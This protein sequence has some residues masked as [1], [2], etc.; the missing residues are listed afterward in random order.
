[1]NLDGHSVLV[2]GA[3][4]FVGGWLVPELVARGC[5]VAATHH[6]EQSAGSADVAWF[7]CELSDAASVRQLIERTH[8]DVVVHLAALA[9]PREA[10][11][12]PLRALQSN[13]VAVHHLLEAL[14]SHTQAAR[15]L[16]V[17][18]GEVYGRRARSAARSQESDPLLPE[19]VYAA[20][21]AAAE[22]RIE[23]AHR[24]WGL[25]VV[26]ARPFN[27]T[28]PGRPDRY[29]E[30]SFAR[31]IAAAEQ[32]SAKPVLRVGNLAAERDF[33]DVRDVVRAYVTLLERGV[34]GEIYNVCSGQ[35][36]SI[37]SI[38]DALISHARLPIEVQ[39]DAERF[40]PT[41]TGREALVGCPDALTRLGWHPTW[42]FDETLANLLEHWRHFARPTSVTTS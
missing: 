39:V 4:G 23:L 13:Y 12:A 11:R 37:R 34:T 25:D 19:N 16:F 20:T 35:P 26:I 1:M 14:R 36:R 22:R 32:G 15:L 40:E 3:S 9:V 27:H 42:S 18:S 2:T 30:S 33:L 29:A 8:P 6:P 28:G 41:P 38:L 31:Q 10:R 5:N 7:P 24:D 21:K 17:S